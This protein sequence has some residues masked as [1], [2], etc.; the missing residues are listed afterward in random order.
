MGMS[1]L[2][3]AEQQICD[4]LNDCENCLDRILD[5]IDEH[6]VSAE[7]RAEARAEWRKRLF[8]AWLA[9]G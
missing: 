4:M 1:H 5:V 6:Y 9:H 3:P 8:V 2:T 7:A